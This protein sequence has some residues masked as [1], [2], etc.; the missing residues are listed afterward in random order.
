MPAKQSRYTWAFRFASFVERYGTLRLS[1]LFVLMTLAFTMG[2]S[3]VIRLSLGS[4]PTLEDYM[5]A[6]IL[7]MLSAPWLLYF[8]SELVKQLEHSRAH[9]KEVI[10]ELESLREEDILLNKELQNN[11]KQLNYEI[12]QRRNAQLEREKVFE[13]LEKEIRDKSEQEIQARRLSMLLRSIIDASPD[14]IY[15]RNEEGKFAGCNRVAED[16]TGRTQDELLGLT[17]HQVYDE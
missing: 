10:E 1:V 12:E 16:L 5:S 3:Y 6:L 8:F 15:Y 13:E 4:D 7:T 2:G 14:L 17:P 9:L 11:I